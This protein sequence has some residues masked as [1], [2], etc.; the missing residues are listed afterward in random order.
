ME[1]PQKYLECEL[2][3]LTKTLQLVLDDHIKW[4]K[5]LTEVAIV[6]GNASQKSKMGL[7]IAPRQATKWLLS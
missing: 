4:K 2:Q 3:A 6:L 1:H 7:R 5:E